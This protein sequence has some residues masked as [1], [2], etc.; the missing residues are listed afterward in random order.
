M[1]DFID[2]QSKKEA[3]SVKKDTPPKAANRRA[4]WT[5]DYQEAQK[6]S[7]TQDLPMRLLFTGSDWCGYCIQLKEGVFNKRAFKKF[8]D[9]NIVLMKADFPRRSQKSATKKQ[10]AKLKK[11]FE[12]SG[13]PSVFILSPSGKKLGRI[14]GY[15]GWSEDEY[16]RRI[17]KLINKS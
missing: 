10:N 11:E 7:K 1:Q 17:E 5:E 8:A 2:A 15:G 3:D 12:V 4:K 6:E 9:K 14:H 13:Y 16:I